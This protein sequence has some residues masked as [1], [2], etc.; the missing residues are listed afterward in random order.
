MGETMISIVVILYYLFKVSSFQQI[1][2][3]RKNSELRGII[4]TP[5]CKYTKKH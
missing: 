5:I 3:N 2:E 1:Y 4:V